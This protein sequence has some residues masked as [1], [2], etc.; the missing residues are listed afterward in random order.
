ME[1]VNFTFQ[2]S[3]QSWGQREC[4]NAGIKANERIR[5]YFVIEQQSVHVGAGRL[6][7]AV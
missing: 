5:S 3:Q 2:L 6:G 7:A 1:N 4:V